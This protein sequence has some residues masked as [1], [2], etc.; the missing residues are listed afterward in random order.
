VEAEVELCAKRSPWRLYTRK[1]PSV[2][3]STVRPKSGSKVAAVGTQRNNRSP[4]SRNTPPPLPLPLL[5]APTTAPAPALAPA[6]VLSG[7]RGGAALR[8]E[9]RWDLAGLER[10]MRH[11]RQ[12]PSW[13]Q[14]RRDTVGGSSR[15]PVADPGPNCRWDTLRRGGEEAWRRGGVWRGERGGMGIGDGKRQKTSEANTRKRRRGVWRGKGRTRGR[16]GALYREVDTN[17]ASLP[18]HHAPRA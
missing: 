12:V 13:P 10:L 4:P 8:T 11:T 7:V 18:P 5:P 6:P 2:Y 15:G 16:A 3:P 9:T 14:E 17:Q 1:D